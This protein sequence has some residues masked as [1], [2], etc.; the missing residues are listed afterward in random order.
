MRSN[1]KVC[2]YNM[3]DNMCF[4]LYKRMKEIGERKQTT[5]RNINS[6]A[7][8]AIKLRWIVL[9]SY[10]MK[11]SLLCWTANQQTNHCYD[12]NNLFSFSLF[13]ESFW[14]CLDDILI[15]V[16]MCERHIILNK[17]SISALFAFICVDWAIAIVSK[18]EK[19][20]E[21]LLIRSDFFITRPFFGCSNF[22]IAIKASALPIP[23]IIQRAAI[24]VV[25]EK[26]LLC[27][28][29][30]REKWN[31]SIPLKSMAFCFSGT[32]RYGSW[33]EHLFDFSRLERFNYMLWLYHRL[34]TT[35]FLV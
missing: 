12:N 26:R 10:K 1:R 18:V 31:I 23:I 21:M 33:L 20:N 30:E 25:L 35:F 24:K 29:T 14:M 28:D 11:W 6:N 22:W 7:V 34:Q 13:I 8:D 19:Y 2:P 4:V 5:H 32:F 9:H 27:W 16:L 17:K 3:R 15:E